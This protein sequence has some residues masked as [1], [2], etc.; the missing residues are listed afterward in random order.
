MA[1]SFGSNVW[2][3]N[4][5]SGFSVACKPEDARDVRKMEG[6]FESL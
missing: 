2:K 4:P 5:E 3:S 6:E 1:R